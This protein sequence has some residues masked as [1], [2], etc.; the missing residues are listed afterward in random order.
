MEII[1]KDVYHLLTTKSTNLHASAR[2][3]SPFL[4]KK[5]GKFFFLLAMVNHF[6]YA[7]FSMTLPLWF[8]AFFMNH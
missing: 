1:P 3:F 2:N 7:T 6:I 5:W 4:L 8:F